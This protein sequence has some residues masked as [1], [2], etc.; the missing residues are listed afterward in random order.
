MSDHTQIGHEHRLKIL[1]STVEELLKTVQRLAV[2]KIH[3]FRHCD[4]IVYDFE[5]TGNG[6]T[7]DTAITQIGAEKLRFDGTQWTR[8]SVWETLVLPWKE[9]SVDVSIFGP[10]AEDELSRQDGSDVRNGVSGTC[11]MRHFTQCAGRRSGRV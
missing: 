11:Q 7:D 9:V 1:E 2:Q 5:T 3:F 10:R 4:L 8:L 6:K